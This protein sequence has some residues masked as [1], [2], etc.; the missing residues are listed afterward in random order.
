MNAARVGVVPML[1]LA[2]F[3]GAGR[4]A[5][6]QQPAPAGIPDISGGWLRLDTGSGSFDGT[7]QTIP[8]AELTAAGRSMVVRG[9][10][11]NLIPSGDV[12]GPAKQAGEAYI[13][14]NGACTPEGT[15]GSAIN[16]N[17]TAIFLLQSKEEVLMVREGPG[18]RRFHLD[19][20][21]HPDPSR[22][23]PSMYG[24]STGRYEGNALIV[25][26]VGLSPGSVQ[27]GGR[28]RPETRL[29]ERFD[30]APDGKHLT[31]TYT[32]DDP[33]LYVRPHTYQYFFER[34]PEGSYALE[35]WCD[36]S[37]PLQRQS[38]V[39]PKQLD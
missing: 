21:A 25:E 4:G 8:P 5:A 37:D 19:G 17:S 3:I 34:L 16:P 13:V 18:G 7:A 33:V 12:T 1:L 6:A 23:T 14:N 20:R 28:R 26:T 22:L 15:G 38:I 32:W 39:P 30:L 27:G 9:D 29:I 35:T 24:H 2:A 11:R 31:I 36:S 10:G